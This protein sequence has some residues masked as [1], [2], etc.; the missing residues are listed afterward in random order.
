[1]SSAASVGRWDWR[2]PKP[3]P[4]DSQK[5]RKAGIAGLS[6]AVQNHVRMNSG[7]KI[8]VA[9]GLAAL[10]ASALLL[11][12]RP[13]PPV[14]ARPAP[15]AAPPR[16]VAVYSVSANATDA[17]IQQALD[18]LPVTGGEVVLPPGDFVI[19]Q[20]IHLNRDRQT[21]RG[22][23]AAS[24]LRLADQ[25]NCPVIILGSTEPNPTNV[26]SQLRLADLVIDGNRRNQRVEE[27]LDARNASGIQNNGVM[28]QSVSNSVI[29]RVVA[30]HCRSGG[31][32]TAVYVRSLT[33]RDFT[34]FDNEFDGLACYRTEDCVF[35]KMNLH[36]N[37]SAGISLDNDFHHNVISDST[38]TANDLGIFMRHSCSNQVQ[39]LTIRQSLHDGVFIAQSG[40]DTPA[41]W[42]FIPESA[43][44]GNRFALCQIQGCAGAAF[45]V[46]DAACTDNEVVGG[47]F[48][49]NRRGGVVQAAT[50]L[51]KVVGL[52]ER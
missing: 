27:W 1:M 45:R 30:A 6:R 19:R 49:N 37:Q 48:R 8:I 14:P 9:C 42:R 52:L 3:P 12:P 26:F 51:V 15:P 10:L 11:R 50:D 21:L 46:N 47:L 36:D 18:R 38:L 33:V 29:E 24:V 7:M 44:I 43:C 4:D 17:E 35:T 40:H 28:V 22:T 13:A 2:P 32:V 34:A 23:G 16:L 31:L 5:N 41:G 39:N 20:P 25:A